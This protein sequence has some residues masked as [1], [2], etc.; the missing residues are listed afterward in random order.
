[1][2]TETGSAQI[3]DGRATAKQIRSEVKEN[4]ERFIAEYGRPPGLT[5]I[6]LGEDPASQIYTRNKERSA[7]KCGMHSEL[8]RLP[9]TIGE[10]ELIGIIKRLN[11]DP[12]VDGILIQLPLP[13]NMNSSRV[14]ES[15]DARKD[16]DGFHP[17]NSG[18]LFSGGEGLF[19][20]TPSG[21][22]ELLKRYDVP[23]KGQH[24]VV[25]GRSNIVGKPMAM[26]LLREHCTVTICH[27]RTVDLAAHTSRADILVAAA[28]RPG[29]IRAEHVKPG[30]VVIDV[31]IHR[32][33]TTD[34]VREYFGE[35]ESRLAAVETKGS[36]LVG[37]VHP[38]EVFPRAGMVTPVPGGVGPLTIALLLKNTLA[39][40]HRRMTESGEQ[41]KC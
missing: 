31:G 29:I 27:S 33:T 2:S 37:D 26:L 12:A 30:A 36:T 41:K 23:L 38:R 35:D 6:L 11:A 1:M 3:L 15:V 7:R 9:E 39:A 19:P 16:V 28:G 22:I 20:C 13:A 18:A 17:L 34:E 25:L 32:L 14:L 21:V 5:V 8:M 24:A 4:S 10:D 40:A